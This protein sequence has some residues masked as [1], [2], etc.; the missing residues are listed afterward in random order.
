VLEHN[1]HGAKEDHGGKAND[2]LLTIPIK[3]GSGSITDTK[4]M[5]IAYSAQTKRPPEGGLSVALMV[6][7]NQATC[8]APFFRR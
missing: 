1:K 7:L 4:F 5:R 2:D 3:Q 6:M 8:S